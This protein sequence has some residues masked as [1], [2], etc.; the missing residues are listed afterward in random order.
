[1]DV[2]RNPFVGSPIT[3]EEIC[4]SLLRVPGADTSPDFA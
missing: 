3:N 4:Q 1:M 2:S